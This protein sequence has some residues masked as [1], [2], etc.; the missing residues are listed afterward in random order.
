MFG[1][2]HVFLPTAL[3]GMGFGILFVVVGIAWIIGHEWFIRRRGGQPL[4]RTRL[5][6]IAFS[7]LFI[8]AGSFVVI[9]TYC[10]F[11]EASHVIA[12]CP[13]QPA[14]VSTY[15]EKKVTSDYNGTR[16]VYLFYADIAPRDAAMFSARRKI[17]IEQGVQ[18]GTLPSP[19]VTNAPGEVYLPTSEN[20]AV[21]V[22]AGKYL[23]SN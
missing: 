1:I 16:Y 10:R 19:I 4:G 7:L 17:E 18:S 5:F 20:L 12:T 21:I 6:Q 13:P 22:V 3:R 9:K 15:A 11:R 14:W 23:C 2:D 8:G